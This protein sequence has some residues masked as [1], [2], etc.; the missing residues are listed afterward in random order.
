MVD[1]CV[2]LANRKISVNVHIFYENELY[3]IDLLGMPSC[4]E[5]DE[6]VYHFQHE[7]PFINIVIRI[8]PIP[9]LEELQT[10]ITFRIYG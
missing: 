6:S 3:S 4:I 8:F 10:Q 7:I 9:E 1:I 2:F 5:V